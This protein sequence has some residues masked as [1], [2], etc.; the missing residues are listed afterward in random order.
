ML[1]M[2]VRIHTNKIPDKDLANFAIFRTFSLVFSKILKIL[3]FPLI[4]LVDREGCTKKIKWKPRLS[5]IFENTSEKVRKIAKFAR[6]LSGILFV[7]ILTIIQSISPVSGFTR[8]EMGRHSWKSLD[9]TFI[10]PNERIL[11]YEFRFEI[12]SPTCLYLFF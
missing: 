4:F 2:M 11:S 7:W 6:S 12:H 9:E 8:G 10:L 3:G 1:F 5:K